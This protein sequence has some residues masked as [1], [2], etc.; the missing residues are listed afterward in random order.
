MRVTS[1]GF[2]VRRCIVRCLSTRSFLSLGREERWH[3]IRHSMNFGARTFRICPDEAKVPLLHQISRDQAYTIDDVARYI[4]AALVPSDAVVGFILS[5]EDHGSERCLDYVP[6]AGE[7]S[8]RS[9]T[10]L[11][12]VAPPHL[13]STSSA[14]HDCSRSPNGAQY[15]ARVG[16]VSETRG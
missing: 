9:K 13:N 8:A 1:L 6:S 15:L 7:R 4:G 12:R 14:S 16:G 3:S 2:S 11:H 5:L 10:D